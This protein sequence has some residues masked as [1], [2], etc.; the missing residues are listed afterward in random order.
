VRGSVSASGAE[1]CATPTGV[2][3]PLA[4]LPAILDRRL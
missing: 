2:S 4:E 3:Q 1:R